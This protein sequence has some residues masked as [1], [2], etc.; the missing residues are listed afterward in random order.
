MPA[1]LPY[2]PQDAAPT[3]KIWRRV[4][5]E[6]DLDGHERRP[7][8]GIAAEAGRGDEEVQQHRRL[9]G[10][11]HEHVAARAGAAQQRLGDPRRQ[12]RRDRGVD[13][14]AA[15]AQ[16]VRSRLRGQRVTGGDHALGA[17]VH[18]T[19]LVVPLHT[20][21]HARK[22]GSEPAGDELRHVEL[23]HAEAAAARRGGLGLGASRSRGAGR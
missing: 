10:L 6:V 23:A 17:F 11:G 1:G 19:R 22:R 3:W 9:A 18:G 4:A 20:R 13:G 16:H 12:H 21:T 8:L 15:R 7:I 5:G 14:V 2:V